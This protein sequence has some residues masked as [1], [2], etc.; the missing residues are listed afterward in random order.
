MGACKS[1]PNHFLRVVL[2]D[3]DAGMLHGGL[4]DLIVGLR[5]GCVSYAR[6]SNTVPPNICEVTHCTH[7]VE[8]IKSPL[9]VVKLAPLA[10]TRGK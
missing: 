1:S 9:S 3:A 6:V 8:I 4:E 10:V 5:L 2:R 7:L